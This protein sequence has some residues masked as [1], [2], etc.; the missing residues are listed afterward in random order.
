MMRVGLFTSTW[1]AVGEQDVADGAQ[2]PAPDDQ[3]NLKDM[4][5]S[6]GTKVGAVMRRRFTVRVIVQIYECPQQALTIA[7]LRHGLLSCPWRKAARCPP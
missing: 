6:L 5:C 3:S 1:T 2:V 7:P 4:L